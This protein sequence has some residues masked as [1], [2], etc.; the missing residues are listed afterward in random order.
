MSTPSKVWVGSSGRAPMLCPA[1]TDPQL[2]GI[3]S[4]QVTYGDVREELEVITELWIVALEIE[5]H[6]LS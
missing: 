1:V 4:A 2:M 3:A 5:L 6:L